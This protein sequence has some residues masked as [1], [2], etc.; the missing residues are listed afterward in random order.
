M[1][2]SAGLDPKAFRT[3]LRNENLSWHAHRS[4]WAVA[5]GGPEH[6]DLERVLLDL[7]RKSE[8]VRGSSAPAVA[9]SGRAESDESWV[10]HLCDQVL[11]LRARRQHRFPFLLGDPGPS[12]RR[13]SLPVDA[14][15][16]ELGLVIEYHERQHTGSVAFFDRRITLSGISRGEQRRRYDERRRT[17]L[18]AHGLDLLILSYSEFAHN[19]SGRLLRHAEDR[20]IVAH[21]LKG[22]S[23][24]D[25]DA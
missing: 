15:Y 21:R 18:P 20:A 11:G 5:V 13:R 19:R 23:G 22:L 9:A 17:L 3:A 4:R 10:I 8:R 25:A 6:A 14:Y 1:A 24:A 2:R 12:G 7:T 16:S